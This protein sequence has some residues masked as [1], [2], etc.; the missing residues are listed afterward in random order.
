MTI[1]PNEDGQVYA[2]PIHVRKDD[3]DASKSMSLVE[4]VDNADSH[5]SFHIFSTKKIFFLY[6]IKFSS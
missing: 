5:V 6:W 3:D 4:S 2:V 1:M